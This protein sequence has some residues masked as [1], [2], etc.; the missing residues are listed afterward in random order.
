MPFLN[1]DV[2]EEFKDTA[3]ISLLRLE[4]RELHINRDDLNKYRGLTKSHPAKG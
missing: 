3:G 4:L 2:L 1:L